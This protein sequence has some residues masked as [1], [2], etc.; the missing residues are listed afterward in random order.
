MDGRRFLKGPSTE[1]GVFVDG[2]TVSGG[3][4]MKMR[5]FMDG[6]GGANEGITKVG[7]IAAIGFQNREDAVGVRF[8]GE[9]IG[10]MS[11]GTGKTTGRDVPLVGL[12]DC[13]EKP[14]AFPSW[15]KMN[16]PRMQAETEDLRQKGA[17]LRNGRKKLF[18]GTSDDIEIVHIT[19]VVPELQVPLHE[20]IQH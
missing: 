9:D 17:Y 11:S 15:D 12:D 16:L 14:D 13:T 7:G 19:S 20:V 5:G 6:D 18:A 2:D 8:F 10:D 4:S 1:I 3:S